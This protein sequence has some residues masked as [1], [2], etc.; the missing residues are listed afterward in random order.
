MSS[1]KERERI[2]ML[3]VL[4]IPTFLYSI[5]LLA[6]VDLTSSNVSSE[7]DPLTVDDPFCSLARF[8]LPL[9]SITFHLRYVL[10]DLD[11]RPLAP[12]D[13]RWPSSPS[14][15]ARRWLRWSR[16]NDVL[17]WAQGMK[18][19]YGFKVLHVNPSRRLYSGKC[20][21]LWCVELA[22]TPQVG[23]SLALAHS[24]SSSSSFFSNPRSWADFMV[25]QYVTQ[26]R[27]GPVEPVDRFFMPP[28]DS[29]LA[30]SP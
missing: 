3:N 11:L 27:L 24:S 1:R 17:G 12:A 30:P 8:S 10:S 22:R 25:D 28:P 29:A 14:L 26:V 6:C 20:V 16:R 15:L 9:F 21:Y 19:F 7:R 4:R 13:I 18:A 2:I 5:W 23:T